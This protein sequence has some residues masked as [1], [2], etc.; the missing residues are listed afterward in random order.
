MRSSAQRRRGTHTIRA[1]IQPSTWIGS[2]RRG[3][4]HRIGGPC[5]IEH[6]SMN[7]FRPPAAC[8]TPFP[9]RRADR[10]SPFLVRVP[11]P[12][13]SVSMQS[14]GTLQPS[15]GYPVTRCPRMRNLMDSTQRAS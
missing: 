8:G 6:Q 14:K 3:T 13:A 9:S 15:R 1:S 11:D 5:E 10:I 12:K 2:S 4:R 7:T